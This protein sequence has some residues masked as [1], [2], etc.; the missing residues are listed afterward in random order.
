MVPL[1]ELRPAVMAPAGGDLSSLP[2]FF[3]ASPLASLM[4]R[5]VTGERGSPLVSMQVYHMCS[6]AVAVTGTRR[7]VS[8]PFSFLGPS[9]RVLQEWIR[10][11]RYPPRFL[12][13][14]DKSTCLFALAPKSVGGGGA[15]GPF[16]K[17]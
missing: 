12:V 4:F 10:V 16:L 8:P 15:I 6:A 17:A 5:G 3:P 13:F 7:D 1:R 11:R 2:Y 9:P 14:A